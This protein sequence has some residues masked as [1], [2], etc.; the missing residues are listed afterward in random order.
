MRVPREGWAGRWGEGQ[1]LER[2]WDPVWGPQTLSADH[3]PTYRLLCLQA[4]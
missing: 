2:G 3:L 4:V 1:A